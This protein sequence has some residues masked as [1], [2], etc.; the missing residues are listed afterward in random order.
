MGQLV[1]IKDENQRPCDWPKGVIHEI[2]PG[3]DGKV[4]VV[5][6]RTAKGLQQRSIVKLIPLPVEEVNP[7]TGGEDVKNDDSIKKPAP[8]EQDAGA[9]IL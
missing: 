3:K 2:H 1:L 8:A 9:E 5:T 7:S 4:R 6:V